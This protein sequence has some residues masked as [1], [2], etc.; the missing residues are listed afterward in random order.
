MTAESLFVGLLARNVILDTDG[1]RIGVTPWSAVSDPERAAI[2]ARKIDLI[3]LLTNPEALAQIIA[4]FCGQHRIDLRGFLEN[5][6]AL[7]VS[8][9]KLNPVLI[10]PAQSILE[11]CREYG[12]ALE[13]DDNGDLAARKEGA[14]PDEPTQ[15][16]PTLIMALE[17]HLD[18][19]AALVRAGWT[20]QAQLPSQPGE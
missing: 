8:V 12:V 10:S 14:K 16:W 7:K 1:S 4:R 18:D 20:L 17:A 19:V 13:I 15:P 5:N 9:D 3:N 2:R 11:T 6:P